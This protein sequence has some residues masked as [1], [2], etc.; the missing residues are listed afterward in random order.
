M[1]G[2]Q[3]SIRVVKD[4]IEITVTRDEGFRVGALN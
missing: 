3:V 4:A 1:D 2:N